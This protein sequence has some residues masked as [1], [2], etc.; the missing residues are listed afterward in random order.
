MQVETI[1]SPWTLPELRRAISPSR[2]R[3]YESLANGDGALA[4]QLYHWNTALSESL[5]GPLQGL[6]ITLRN[7]VNERLIFNRAPPSLLRETVHQQ[8]NRARQLRNRVAHH[9]P[10]LH[11][12][13]ADEYCSILSMIQ[14]LC[15]ATALYTARQSQFQSVLE[16]RPERTTL[17]DARVPG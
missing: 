8:L 16:N 9:E 14:W 12:K 10:T 17:R 7:A 2:L 5:H 13:L 1:Y 15:L 6:E 11:L 4:V 3:R